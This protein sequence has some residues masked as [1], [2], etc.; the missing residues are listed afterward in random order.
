MLFLELI[1]DG[2]G[3]I[4]DVKIQHDGKTGQQVNLQPKQTSE[5]LLY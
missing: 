2:Q 4:E 3:N 1:F 5:L